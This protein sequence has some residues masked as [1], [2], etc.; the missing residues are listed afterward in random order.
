L[1]S[2]TILFD[3]EGTL[4]Q[5]KVDDSKVLDF[6]MDELKRLSPGAS[7]QRAYG[8][9]ELLRQ[10]EGKVEKSA[11]EET[12]KSVSSRLAEAEKAAAPSARE[13]KD[14]RTAI[15][16]L[17]GK[18][19]KAGVITGLSEQ[20]AKD[21]LKHVNLEGTVTIFGSRDD[22]MDRKDRIAFALKKSDSKPGDTILVADGPSDV[23]AARSSGV[24]CFAV[25]TQEIP[26]NKVLASKPDAFLYSISEL[27]DTMLLF[28]QQSQPQQAKPAAEAGAPRPGTAPD[29]GQA[30]EAGPETTGGP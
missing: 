3:L 19:I 24:R 1:P 28:A 30:A 12:K 26:V 4:I 9:A 15:S 29:A 8:L 13:R 20:G 6:L 22:A 7:F 17:Q 18:G 2:Q 21:A 23:E 25:Y 11:L 27:E 5:V 10:A 16:A 14:A